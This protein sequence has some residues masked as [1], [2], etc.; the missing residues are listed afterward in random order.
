MV[1][2]LKLSMPG[3]LDQTITKKVKYMLYT[4]DERLK[5]MFKEMAELTKN[6]CLKGCITGL[7][8]C[9]SEDYCNLAK[10]N[11][12]EH[13]LDIKDTRCSSGCLVEPWLR[14]ICTV[15]ICERLY[16]FDNEFAEEYFNLREEISEYGH[17]LYLNQNK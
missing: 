11:A 3:L 7:G 12:R 6:A 8:S 14:P 16:M 13:G 2:K 1:K 17:N 10:K 9:C 4:P 5:Y 15:H